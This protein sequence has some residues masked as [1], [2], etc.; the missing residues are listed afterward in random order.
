L[1]RE[2]LPIFPSTPCV[3]L[4]IAIYLARDE[5]LKEFLEL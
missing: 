5:P 4:P 3:A 1:R 2:Q